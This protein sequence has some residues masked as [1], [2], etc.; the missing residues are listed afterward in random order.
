M[1][2][3]ILM[4]ITLLYAVVAFAAVEVNTATEAELDSIKGIGPA[5]SQRIMAERARG[6][7]KDWADLKARVKGLGDK[8]SAKFSG[9]G[10]RVNGASFDKSAQ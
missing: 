10:L 2:K 1:W 4:F 5:T 3:N 9:G 6:N 7:F 8:N